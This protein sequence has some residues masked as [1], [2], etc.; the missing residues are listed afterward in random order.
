M[1]IIQVS[2]I[3][4]VKPEK[5]RQ[6]EDMVIRAAQTGQLGQKIDEDKLISLL[7][8]IGEKKAAPTKITVNAFSYLKTFFH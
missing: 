1:G 5:A 3:K 6:V 2:R 7:E 4:L 8:Q